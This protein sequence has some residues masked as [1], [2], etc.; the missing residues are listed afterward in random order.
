MNIQSFCVPTSL[1]SLITAWATLKCG[2][3]PGTPGG[4]GGETAAD[5]RQ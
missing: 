2:G 3:D 4:I 5:W 1:E